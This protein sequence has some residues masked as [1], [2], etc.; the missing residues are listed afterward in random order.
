MGQGGPQKLT[1]LPGRKEFFNLLR[2]YKISCKNGLQDLRRLTNHM[3][4]MRDACPILVIFFQN[5]SK[6]LLLALQLLKIDKAK[7]LRHA[8]PQSVFLQVGKNSVI[9]KFVI[10]ML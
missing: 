5:I 6:K 8:I 2:T 10:K 7:K 9:C 4:D 1:R 3:Q